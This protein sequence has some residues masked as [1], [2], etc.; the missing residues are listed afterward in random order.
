MTALLLSY[1]S[2]GLLQTPTATIWLFVIGTLAFALAC[3]GLGVFTRRSK[4]ARVMKTSDFLGQSFINLPV[5]LCIA[6]V[7]VLLFLQTP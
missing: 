5:L 2:G 4:P 6:S 3:L 1:F 7:I